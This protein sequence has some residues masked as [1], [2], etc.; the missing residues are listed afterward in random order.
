MVSGGWYL[1]LVSLWPARSR[2]YI[3]GS[4]H[5]SIVELALG[6]NGVGRLTGNETGGL[7]NLNFDVGWA[8]LFGA[9]MGSHIAWLLPSAVI[10]ICAGLLLTRRAPR[11]DTTRAAL[12]IWGGWLAVTALVFSYANGILHPYYTVALAP[13]V[14]AGLATGTTMLWQRRTDIRAATTLCGQTAVTAALAYV[15]L[16]QYPQ[17]LPWLR[18]AVLIGGIGTPSCCR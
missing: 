14:G 18:V 1:A 15:L 9:Q 2:P 5:N 10:A 16:Q 3:G 7:G 13:A 11:T 6:Y 17:W 4:Q 8:R 12:L